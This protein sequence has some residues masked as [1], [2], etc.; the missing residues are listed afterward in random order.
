MKTV[1]FSFSL[2]VA[3]SGCAS[4]PN[5]S[6][7][8]T[9]HEPPLPYAAF[10]SSRTETAG[11]ASLWATSPNAL[12]GMRRAKDLGDLLTVT[13]EMDDRA[14]VQ[15]SLSRSR[16][17][18]ENLGVGSLFGLPEWAAGVLP[19]G[20]TL[21]PGVDLESTSD[22]NGQGAVNRAEKIAFTLAARVI[23][24][25][26][27]GNLI[28]EGRQQTQVSDEVRYLA[29]SGVIRTQDIGR[30][31]T[32]SYDKIAEARLTY[33]SD[34]EATAPVRSGVLT[35]TLDRVRPF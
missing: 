23:G 5:P 24:V 15:N 16:D 19:G 8:P 25:E 14:S 18:T 2:F 35:R 13:V 29:V 1:S 26:P 30:D 9:P 21:S 11:A 12:L 32:V 10:P 17:A 27:N 22:L 3:V 20:A 28:I 7:G 33:V 34:G 31:N 6:F 4:T